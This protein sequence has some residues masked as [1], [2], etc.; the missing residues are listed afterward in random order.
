MIRCLDLAGLRNIDIS[1]GEK[2]VPAYMETLFRSP[3]TELA[4]LLCHELTTKEDMLAYKL[5]GVIENVL[6][7]CKHK[8]IDIE[9]FIENKMKYN[10]TRTYKHGGKKY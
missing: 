9:Y 6:L 3:F 1:I 7:Y 4:Y 5:N 2:E 8:G 10:E